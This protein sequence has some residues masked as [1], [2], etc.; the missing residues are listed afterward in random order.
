MKISVITVCLNAQ[1]T[2][3]ETLYS[4]A[5]QTYKDIEHIV[6]DGNSKDKTLEI[7]HSFSRDNLK[8]ISESDS[9]IY[10]AMNK[11]IQAA[12][13]DYLFFLNANDKFLH[14]KVI[15]IFATKALN[16]N[17]DMVYGTFL[18]LNNKT[19]EYGIKKQTNLNKFDLWKA[20]PF[21]P[22]LF[23][24]KNLFDKFGLFS[25]DY[26]IVSD[27]EWMLRVLL[28]EKLHLHYLDT[29]ITLFDI[30]GISNSDTDLPKKERAVI[31]NLYFS[32]FE[33]IFFNLI[34]KTAQGRKFARTKLFGKLFQIPSTI[35]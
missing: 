22:T 12:T 7:I 11:G 35:T 3:R 34:N 17:K 2:I 5:S 14:D 24:K 30:S 20:S 31:E 21:Q 32:K 6:V 10:E 16:L 26:K 1:D 8:I 27:Y 19:G 13:G 25:T 18:Q 29:L 33:L 23:Y 4:V 9:G 15:E 28:N